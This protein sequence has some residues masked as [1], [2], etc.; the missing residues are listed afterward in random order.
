MPH[1]LL[2][3][4]RSFACLV[5]AALARLVLLHFRPKSLSVKLRSH[6]RQLRG[7]T[8]QH[9]RSQNTFGRPTPE[10]NLGSTLQFDLSGC[11]SSVRR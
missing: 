7:K 5:S 2:A 3:I 11:Q 6:F 8:L 1:P 10:L 4:S 9:P